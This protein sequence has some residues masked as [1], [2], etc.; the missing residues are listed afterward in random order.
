MAMNT[1]TI[2]V[3]IFDNS[4]DLERADKQ[5]ATAGFEAA[6]HDEA[7]VAQ[8]SSKV[9][10]VPVGSVLAPGGPTDDVGTVESDSSAIAAFRS[11]LADCHLPDDVI[12]AYATAFSHNGKFVLVRTEP[13]CAKHVTGILEE[14]SA[15]RVNRHDLDTLL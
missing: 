1:E 8:E 6:I 7:I 9:S 13:E 14:C 4:Q 12:D 2:V 11:H 3:G 10:P 15:T 5:L